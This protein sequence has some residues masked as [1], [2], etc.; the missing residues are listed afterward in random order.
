MA[1]TI[2]RT[3]S[4]TAEIPEGPDLET[5]RCAHD[6]VMRLVG[7]ISPAGNRRELSE[8]LRGLVAGLTEEARIRGVVLSED[9]YAELAEAVMNIEV[10]SWI[11]FWIGHV[12]GPAEPL[13]SGMVAMRHRTERDG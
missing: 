12:V 11:R 13:F 4:D 8:T 2:V 3:E 9:D 7:T 1:A 5:A 10:A 6:A